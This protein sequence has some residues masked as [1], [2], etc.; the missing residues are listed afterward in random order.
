MWLTKA[1]TSQEAPTFISGSS[2]LEKGEDYFSF[3]ILN[4]N[5]NITSEEIIT[6]FLKFVLN[7]IE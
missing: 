1:H 3:Q 7:I 2:S 6:Y 5:E 4:D